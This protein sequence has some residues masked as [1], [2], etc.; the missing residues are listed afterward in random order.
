VEKW[1]DKN[2]TVQKVDLLD[3]LALALLRGC[4]SR[5]KAAAPGTLLVA[6]NKGLYDEDPPVGLK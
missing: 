6:L 5:N 3:C 2:T 1:K 4:C